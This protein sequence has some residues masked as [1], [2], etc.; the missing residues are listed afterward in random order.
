MLPEN[1]VAGSIAT[2][3]RNG[4][5]RLQTPDGVVF[6]EGANDPDAIN[7][8]LAD[9]HSAVRQAVHRWLTVANIYG[10]GFNSFPINSPQLAPRVV[11]SGRSGLRV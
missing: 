3:L 11:P 10:A 1:A 5:L 9:E 2:R 6:Y 7:D 8:A 4:H